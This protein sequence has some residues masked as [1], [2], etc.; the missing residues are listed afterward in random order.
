MTWQALFRKFDEVWLG[1]KILAAQL[2]ALTLALAAVLSLGI[3]AFDVGVEGLRWLQTGSWTSGKTIEDA[4]PVT[5]ELV[6]GL[7]WL[8][9]QHLGSW[10]ISHS[11]LWFYA[12]L[13][14]LCFVTCGIFLEM[15]DHLRSRRRYHYPTRGPDSHGDSLE[16]LQ[17]SG[18]R[19]SSAQD[20]ELTT[21]PTEVPR[22]ES[23]VS[24]S[25]IASRRRL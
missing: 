12:S 22:T 16:G 13:A 9:V 1:A 18:E 7:A 6:A 10:A 21:G 5:S 15:G 3:V 11:V 24:I 8:G 4:F 14:I 20:E 17:L 2:I 19:K 25:A 23:S